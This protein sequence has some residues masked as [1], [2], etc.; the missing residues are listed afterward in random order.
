M[1]IHIPQAVFQLDE[2]PQPTNALMPQATAGPMELLEPKE[3]PRPNN[4]P[5]PQEI[6]VS[7][8]VLKA[9]EIPEKQGTKRLEITEPQAKAKRRKTGGKTKN[10]TPKL[11]EPPETQEP[12]G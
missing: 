1:E 9:Q 12:L 6:A 4:A 5:K 2:Q 7:M 11:I 3:N 8:K 10:E